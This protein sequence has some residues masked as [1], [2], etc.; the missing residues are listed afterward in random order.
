MK[1]FLTA[2]L[3]SFFLFIL[4]SG[5]A[6]ADFFIPRIEGSWDLH[7]TVEISKQTYILNGI[8]YVTS[9]IDSNDNEVVTN[10]KKMI[11][12]RSHD[13]RIYDSFTTTFT[14]AFTIDRREFT[15]QERGISS[16]F[17]IRN[18][19]TMME[20]SRYTRDRNDYF[21]TCIYTREEPGDSGG[22]CTTGASSPFTFLLALP[23]VFLA[24]KKCC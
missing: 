8:A 4:A 24:F 14:N 15:L 19:T 22:G 12:L 3:V 16:D 6:E 5:S 11:T 23:L 10:L 18:N 9:Y 1:R 21:E 20:Y 17:E 7:G 2:F 13:G